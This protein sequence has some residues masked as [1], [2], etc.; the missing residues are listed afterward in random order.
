MSNHQGTKIG[1]MTVADCATMATGCTVTFYREKK[2]TAN[3][4][5]SDKIGAAS[6]A[7]GV[8]TAS[9]AI[10]TSNTIQAGTGIIIALTGHTAPEST[11]AKKGFVFFDYVIP[12]AEEDL[13]KGWDGS[14]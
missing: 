12:F 4:F 11:G 5:A 9:K 10:T 8:T 7:T 1:F 13:N 6:Y 2:I 14:S 3:I